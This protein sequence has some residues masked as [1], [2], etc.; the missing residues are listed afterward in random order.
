MAVLYRVM[1]KTRTWLLSNM[2]LCSP[3]HHHLLAK[4]QI[5]KRKHCLMSATM[6]QT[7]MTHLRGNVATYLMSVQFAMM[8]H[9]F[10]PRSFFFFITLCHFIDGDNKTKVKKDAGKGKSKKKKKSSDKEALEDS[11]DG[12]Y[13]GLEVDYMSDETR[14]DPWLCCTLTS[15]LKEC[16]LLLQACIS[17]P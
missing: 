3:A 11:D 14:S 7:H 2:C 10:L 5:H 16:F 6:K 9:I 1:V 17:F 15:A 8:I 12:D 4:G 13:E